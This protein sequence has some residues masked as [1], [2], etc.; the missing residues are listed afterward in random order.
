MHLRR[1]ARRT[2]AHSRKLANLKAAVAALGRVVQLCQSQF[3]NPLHACGAG[4][5]GRNDL[6]DEGFDFSLER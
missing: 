1:F 6:D 3:G 4:W 2:N 5:I